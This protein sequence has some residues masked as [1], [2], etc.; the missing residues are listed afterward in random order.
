MLLIFI[1]R[2]QVPLITSVI[3]IL[4]ALGGDFVSDYL[5]YQRHGIVQGEIWRLLTANFL[6]TNINHMLLNLAV[7]WVVWFIFYHACSIR[8]QWTFLLL[9][10]PMTTL[11]LYY[12]TSD[13]SGYVGLSG[14]LYGTMVAFA[15]A[16]LKQHRLTSGILLLGVTAKMIHQSFS[17]DSEWMKQFIESN[18]AEEAHVWGALSGL[19]VGLIYWVYRYY[20]QPNGRSG[21]V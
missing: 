1:K 8:V 18:I 6:H 12:F 14:S 5:S 16:D 20:W 13:I 9:P 4:L 7:M 11:L 10:M 15:I 3:C 2:Y 19:C 21:D 17:E